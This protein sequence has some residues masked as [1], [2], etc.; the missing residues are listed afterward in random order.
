[1]RHA[2]RL[3]GPCVRCRWAHAQ[4]EPPTD[5]E[6]ATV[7]GGRGGDGSGGGGGGG[8]SSDGGGDGGGGGGAASTQGDASAGGPRASSPALT[9]PP[10]GGTLLSSTPSYAPLLSSAA[11]ASTPFLLDTGM[12]HQPWGMQAW[13]STA[14]SA[15]A[16]APDLLHLLTGG[17]GAH[18]PMHAGAASAGAA[19]SLS[20]SMV[21][22]GTVLSAAAAAALLP[23]IVVEATAQS[24]PTHVHARTEKC[25]HCTTDGAPR[26]RDQVP[27][28]LNPSYLDASITFGPDTMAWM[29]QALRGAQARSAQPPRVNVPLH[30]SRDEPG[31]LF[32]YR[33]QS[34]LRAH[35]SPPRVPLA[36]HRSDRALRSVLGERF[37][38]HAPLTC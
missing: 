26:V 13:G 30:L 21:S 17:T 4:D 22:T 37:A 12:A 20:V 3:R 33:P 29:H 1:M 7:G 2:N 23:S 15:S 9:R 32:S 25:T 14:S 18:E 5:G 28:E 35:T 36:T 27:A 10:S 16:S 31:F 6:A 19:G 34:S 8:G 38:F 11:S 24:P